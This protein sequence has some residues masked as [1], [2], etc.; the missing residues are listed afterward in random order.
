MLQL[1]EQPLGHSVL[2]E[3]A[4]LGRGE[5]HLGGL[6]ESGFGGPQPLHD[7][8]GLYGRELLCRLEPE[9]GLL[10]ADGAGGGR[11]VVGL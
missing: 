8:F 11:A 10:S 9:L 7:K 1:V 6:F 3:G 4:W 2:G 5:R